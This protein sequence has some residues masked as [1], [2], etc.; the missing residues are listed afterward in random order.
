MAFDKEGKHF[1]VL[2][3]LAEIYCGNLV[4]FAW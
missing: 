3:L 4:N 2:K 1:L